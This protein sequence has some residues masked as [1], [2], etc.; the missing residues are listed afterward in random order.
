MR[1]TFDPTNY[2]DIFALIMG[3]GALVFV[4][5]ALVAFVELAKTM[6]WKNATHW[7]NVGAGVALVLFGLVVLLTA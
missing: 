7:R 3:A 6:E 4:G 1:M 5:G 2:A